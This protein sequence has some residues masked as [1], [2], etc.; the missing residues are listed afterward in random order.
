IDAGP[1]QTIC[2]GLPAIL[3]AQNCNS[4]AHWYTIAEQ[5]LVPVGEG[6]V[7]DVFPQ[8]STCYVVICCNPAP[9][10]CDTDTVCIKVNPHPVLQWPTVYDSICLNS[11]PIFLN[12]SNIL[13]YVNPNWVPVTTTGGTGFFSGTGVA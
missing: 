2:A 8:T 11:P 4:M 9:C 12:A 6:Q 1:D 5:G 7:L 10:C 13:V 3:S